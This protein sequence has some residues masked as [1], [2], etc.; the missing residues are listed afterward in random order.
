MGK[1]NQSYENLYSL[2]IEIF[3]MYYQVIV[4]VSGHKK[5]RRTRR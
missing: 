2:Y 3:R 5:D 1:V 4:V